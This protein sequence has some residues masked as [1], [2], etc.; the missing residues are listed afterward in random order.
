[1]IKLTNETTKEKGDKLEKEFAE[2]MKNE[3]QY[4]KYRIQKRVKGSIN[5]KGTDVDIIAEKTNDAGRRLK[6]NSLI[7]YIISAFIFFIGFVILATDGNVGLAIMFISFGLGGIGITLVL[8]LE[9]KKLNVSHGWVECK[10]L[11]SKVDLPKI[12]KMLRE[13]KDCVETKEMDARNCTLYFV[14][15]SGFMENALKF[16]IQNRIIC[17]EKN[18]SGEFV[19]SQYWT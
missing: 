6:N 16:A 8:I 1:M 4:E 7:F 17:Y 18:E 9:S 19:Q 15:A 2:F 5:S 12:D 13:Y 11:K 10:N 3:L 14:S